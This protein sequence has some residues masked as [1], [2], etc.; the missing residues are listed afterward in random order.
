MLVFTLRRVSLFLFTMLILTMLSFSLSFL[1]PGD[2]VINLSGQI[3]AT[4][5]ELVQLNQHYKHDSNI[6]EQYF[7]YLKQLDT[8]FNCLL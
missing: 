3:N 8:N 1:F 2:N 5:D 7:V 6:I 4:A